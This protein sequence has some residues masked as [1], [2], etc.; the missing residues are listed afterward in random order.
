MVN[1]QFNKKF[2][3]II[4]YQLLILFLHNYLYQRNI[5][6]IVVPKIFLSGTMGNPFNRLL[7]DK[8]IQQNGLI[9][10]FDHGVGSMVS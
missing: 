8:I 6:K 7:A 9:H 5:D 1:L 10:V 3:Q 4:G 2:F